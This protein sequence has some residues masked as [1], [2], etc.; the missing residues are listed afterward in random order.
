M[1][2]VAGGGARKIVENFKKNT[3]K[4]TPFPSMRGL[5]YSTPKACQCFNIVI[6]SHHE[7]PP[8][9]LYS[10]FMVMIVDVTKCCHLKGT[11]TGTPDSEISEI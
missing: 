5:P 8:L 2:G 11:T 6:V 9:R 7:H 4:R 10:D 3:T 1:V